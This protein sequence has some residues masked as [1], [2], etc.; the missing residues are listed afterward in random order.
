MKE[1]YQRNQTKMKQISI[2]K[3]EIKQMSINVCKGTK[4]LPFII[5]ETVHH[6]TIFFARATIFLVLIG[7]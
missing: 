4:S 2:N 7:S 3:T 1:K 6:I 5:Y